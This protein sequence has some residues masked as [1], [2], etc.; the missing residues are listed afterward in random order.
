[1]V[2]VALFASLFAATSVLAIP[3]PVL[4]ERSGVTAVSAATIA[5]FKPY[6]QFARAAYCPSLSTWKCGA[7]CSALSNFQVTLAGGDGNGI[8]QFYVGYYPTDNTIVVGHEGTDPTQFLSLLT[9][10][11]ILMDPLDSSL[12]PG[13]PSSVQV[14][15]GFRNAHASTAKQILAAVKSLM[16]SKGTNKITTVGHSLGGALAVLEGVFFKTQLPSATI[17]VVTYGLPR[18][19]NQEFADWVDAKIPDLTHITNDNDPIPIVPGRFLGF[20]HPHGEIHIDDNAVWRA[21]A[22]QDNTD[23]QCSTGNTPNI[24]V[25]NIVDHLGSYDGVWLG[26]P[27]CN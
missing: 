6:T 26:T 8:P 4:E 18:V 15:D 2:Y 11:N 25:G 3:A 21:C 9:D 27:F 5:S 19:G 7:A 17:R 1:M 12:F 13:I 22:G 10:A 20:H 14:H 16:A 23:S 24:F